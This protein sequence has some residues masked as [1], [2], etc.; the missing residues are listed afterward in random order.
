MERRI[1]PVILSGGSGTRLWPL[2]IEERP[3]QFLALTGDRTM[4][5]MTAL[6]AAD[7]DRFAPPVVVASARHADLVENQLA[8]IGA[9]PARLVLEPVARNTA[10]AVALA[11]LG[12]DPAALML[13]MPSD[14]LIA[15]E[16]AFHAAVRAAEP[17]ARDGWLVTFGIRPDRPE[18]G[19]GYI[20]RA[21]AIG[22][23]VYRAERFVEKPDAEAA[24]AYVADGGYDWN[25]GIFLFR[26]DAYL[27]ALMKFDP[28]ILKAARAAH[29][30]AAAQ[31]NRLHPDMEAFAG[32]PSR[33]IDHAV[34]ERSDRVAVTPV[35]MGWSDVGSFDALHGLGA[36]DAAG[37]VTD[38]RST[39]IDSSGCLLRSEGPAITVVGLS[40]MIVVA[41]A[42]AV[43]IVRRG[44]SQRVKEAAEAARLGTQRT[45]APG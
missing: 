37:N 3:K 12:L 14:H 8:E 23:R 32:A 40:D 6:R 31:G 27:T 18:T 39:A 13:V 20:L 41:S 7:A 21:E 5:Q 15:D 34:M 38:A 24:A 11:A 25:G 2:S 1:T 43:V 26:A 16:A 4:L 44:E 28:A 29:A 45:S 9:P 19:F 22:E 35:A 30:G 10:P 42:D 17:L 36:P 33:S